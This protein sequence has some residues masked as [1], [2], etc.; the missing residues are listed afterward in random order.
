LH[1]ERVHENKKPFNVICV[2][3]QLSNKHKLEDTLN[4][5]I[6]TETTSIVHLSKELK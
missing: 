6:K 2:N 3:I 4:V 5:F 1:I